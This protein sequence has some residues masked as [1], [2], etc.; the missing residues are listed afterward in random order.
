MT[1]S[2]VETD[3]GNI[4]PV[5]VFGGTLDEEV[6]TDYGNIASVTVTSEKAGTMA[7]VYSKIEL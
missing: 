3:T 2:Y 6:Y 4:G 7:T 1:G 5:Q